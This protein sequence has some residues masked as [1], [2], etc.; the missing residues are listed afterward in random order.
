MSAI[1]TTGR[2][3]ASLL[4]NVPGSFAVHDKGG[5]FG[6]DRLRDAVDAY[7]SALTSAGVAPLDRV[8]VK[9]SRTYLDLAAIFGVAIARGIAVPVGAETPPDRLRMI[10][11]DCC[12][13][14]EVRTSDLGVCFERYGLTRVVDT[15]DAGDLDDVALMIYTSG[16]SGVPKGVVCSHSAVLSAVEGIQDRL[17]YVATDRIGLVL[18]M[19]FDYGLYQGFLALRAGAELF[20]YEE[21]VSGPRL[22]DRLERDGITVLPSLPA[23]TTGLV[24]WCQR[25]QIKLEQVRL[26]TSTGADFTENLASRTREVMP[27]ARV[28][29]MY[30]LTECKRATI[31]DGDP[32]APHNSGRAIKGCR[33]EIHD[34]AGNALASGEMGQVVVVGDNVMKGYWP[35]GDEALNERFGV[36]ADG[37]RFV[38]TGDRGYVDASGGL[39]VLGR[40]DDMFKIRGYR[41]S[42]GEVEDALLE[43]SGVTQACVQPPL[44]GLPYM[45]LYEGDITHID[46]RE[47]LS[48]RLELH[49]VPDILVQVD[50]LAVN[51]NGKLDRKRIA[52]SIRDGVYSA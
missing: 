25:R 10:A 26:L 9:L 38:R 43:V 3:L 36:T 4:S 2:S 51:A 42:I 31:H 13:I 11:E 41:T 23:L 27:N 24:S 34:D 33:I 39:Y 32:D 52:S 18:P 6:I 48:R 28:V 37:A 14:G 1:T 21:A 30:G 22:G 17:G 20:I 44:Q 19:A 40:V 5:T 29:P 49:K 12:A 16:S 47:R 35:L 15:D 50:Q 46:L 7:A 8:I 45:A